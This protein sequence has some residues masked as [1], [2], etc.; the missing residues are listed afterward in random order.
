MELKRREK[1]ENTI[2]K[3][4]KCIWKYSS[5]R[6][7][8]THKG[9]HN[10]QNERKQAQQIKSNVDNKGKIW[11]INWKVQRKNQVPHTI[12]NEK[13]KTECSS[14][15]LEE[16][17]KY[18]NRLKTKTTEETQIEYKVEKKFQ[19]ITN[20]QEN[21]ENNYRN[22][23]KKSNWRNENKKA[24]DRLGWKTE[25]IKKGGEKMVKKFIYFI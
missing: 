7:N 2:S 12:K 20:R 5:N 25:W 18:E 1:T 22:H 11:E 10:R 6:K 3:Y 23:N 13:K 4:G 15:I 17:K 9:T 24:A 14:Q 8:K 19:Q 21:K 16:Y